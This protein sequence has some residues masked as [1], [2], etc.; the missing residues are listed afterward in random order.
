MRQRVQ[1]L[2]VEMKKTIGMFPRMLLWAILLMVLIG[3]I[4]FCGTKGMER[5]PLAAAVDIGVVVQEENALTRMALGYIENLESVS[6]ICH[7]VRLSEEAGFR[8]LEQQEVAALIVLPE[9][10]IEG[11][12]N[13]DNPVVDVFFP[14]N[15]GL[16]TLLLRELTEAGAGLLRVAQAQIYGAYDVA[17]EYGLKEQLSVMEAEIDSYNLAFA[18]DR[19]AIYD[20][21]EVAATGQMSVLQYYL[22]SGVVLF[23]LLMG[24]AVYPVMRQEPKAFCDQLKR[25]GTGCVW[26]C[27][28]RWLCG[29]LCMGLFV[30]AAWALLTTIRVIVPSASAKI[31]AALGGRG[32]GYPAGIWCI[33]F[34]VILVTVSA[35]IYLAYSVSGSRTGSILLIFLLSVIMVY[36]SGGLVPSMF[37]PRV[38]QQ[39]GNLLPTTY[40]IQALGGLL[41]GYADGQLVQCMMVLLGYTAIFGVASYFLRSN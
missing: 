31:S 18:L 21:K 41:A 29:F 9:Q 33:V 30:I 36:L 17:A 1:Y 6:E 19:L 27:F 40:L 28:C 10:L 39:I 23:L 13:G 20:S 2:Y 32:G 16:V 35:L 15:A 38:M 25:Q 11:I 12:M 37:M 34:F 4:A 14:K 24:M 3:M 5:E 8:K 26:Q 22:V 7:F